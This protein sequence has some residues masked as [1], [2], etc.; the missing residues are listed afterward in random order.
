L[1]IADCQLALFSKVFL[2]NDVLNRQLAISNRQS[3][4]GNQQSAIGN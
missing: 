4:I 3:A 2:E 1:P